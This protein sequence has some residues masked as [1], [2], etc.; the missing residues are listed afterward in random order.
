MSVLAHAVV[1]RSELGDAWRLAWAV[2]LPAAVASLLFCRAWLRLRQRG[3][4][5]HA[6]AGRMLLFAAGLA[7]LLLALLSPLDA[8]GEG[9]LLSAHMLQHVA[10]SD[11]AP[12]LLVAAIRGPLVFFLLPAAVLAP[13]ARL[14][15][16]RRVLRLL[17]EPAVAFGLWVV[18]F[19]AW[20]VPGAYDY[21]LTR[22]L[23]HGFEHASFVVAGTLV[24]LQLIDPARRARLTRGRRLALAGLLFACGQVL[25]YVLI[26]SYRPLYPAYAD[27]P[28][29]LF[30]LS[31]LRDQ[32]LAGLVMM[33]EQ[34]LA[35]GTFAVLLLRGAQPRLR[36]ASARRLPAQ[37]PEK[38]QSA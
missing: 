28:E 19:A 22:P 33:A 34:L 14:H 16:L 2:V 17:L 25:A 36:S 4:P 1:P 38:A 9:Y 23:L 32:Q 29:R 15:R 30:G 6:S 3:R 26:F 20:H 10:I 24:W 21:V 7:V 37:P 31:P 35:L 13:L 27:Q 11:A 8:V 12:A 18:V 5:E